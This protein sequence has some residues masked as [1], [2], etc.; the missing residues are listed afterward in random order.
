MQEMNNENGY[1]SMQFMVPTRGLLGYRTEFINETRGEGTMVR[2]F[3]RFEDYKGDIPQRTSGVGIAQEK[4]TT[5]PYAL[6]TIQERIHMFIGP[7]VE[8]YEGM[9]V[10]ENS[11]SDDMV[12]NPWR[13][14]N[15]RR[16]RQARTYHGS[17]ISDRCRHHHPYARKRSSGC[18][19]H[20]IQGRMDRKGCIRRIRGCY[21]VAG[22]SLGYG[23]RPLFQ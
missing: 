2:R 15:R 18:H 19:R 8:V 23:P 9:I 13:K 7:G 4:G 5:T 12:I 20:D 10:G 16:M 22:P 17:R 11:R 6:N 3:S 14:E 21:D 1:V